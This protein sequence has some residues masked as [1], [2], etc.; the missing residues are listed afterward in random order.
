MTSTTLT[1]DGWDDTPDD[2]GALVVD[3]GIAR[4]RR[5]AP[6]TD[7][8]DDEPDFDLDIVRARRDRTPPATDDDQDDDSDVDEDIDPDDDDFDHETV[9]DRPPAVGRP[10]DPHD[11]IPRT[12]FRPTRK[13]IVPEWARG[14]AQLR[15]TARHA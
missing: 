3:L 11:E 12:A 1:P 15:A 6:A 7:G 5:T 10:V 9:D 2:D 4:A 13:P 8:P 14:W